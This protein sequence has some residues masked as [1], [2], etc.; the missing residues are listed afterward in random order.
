MGWWPRL[1]RL[2]VAPFCAVL[3]QAEGGARGC[4]A[5]G[6]GRRGEGR[7]ARG[8]RR[9]WAG[10]GGARRGAPRGTGARS[11]GRARRGHRRARG[12]KRV[13]RPSAFSRLSFA[14]FCA[15]VGG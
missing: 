15:A 13:F 14:P 11:I 12:G 6:G 2:S 7:R 5:A 1:L 10:S 4:R 3:R 9:G 8:E